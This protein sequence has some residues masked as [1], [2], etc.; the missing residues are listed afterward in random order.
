MS[1]ATTTTISTDAVDFSLKL[2]STISKPDNFK[3]FLEAKDGVKIN[4]ATLTRMKI[5]RKRYYK[6]LKQLRDAGLIEKFK[7]VY[8]HTSFGRVVYQ[9][10]IVELIEYKKYFKEMQ[11]VD[12]I[13]GG[14]LKVTEDNLVSFFEKLI[15]IKNNVA[16]PSIAATDATAAIDTPKKT[17]IVRTYEE[18]VALLLKCVDLC[19]EEILI[20][21]RVSPEEI[22]N[23]ILQKC[24]LG[25]HVKVLAD[26]DLVKEYFKLHKI[27][28]ANLNGQDK[29]AVERMNVIGNPWYPEK[30]VNRKICKVPF[31]VIIIDGNEVGIEL[32]D[33]TDP[34]KFNMGI[35]LRDENASRV[36]KEYY[37]KLWSD[38]YSDIAKV[39]D[40]L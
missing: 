29:N 19:K 10:N 33:Q 27:D 23:R 31:G 21:T 5:S 22:I 6:A 18:M 17:E 2:F 7:G 40:E 4:I 30:N 12:D 13:K 39:K 14:N 37:E 1:T 15:G 35:L 8:S 9:R 34:K 38:A 16:S 20:A 11:V 26:I 25:V 32:V 36:M 3:F 24:R 28:K